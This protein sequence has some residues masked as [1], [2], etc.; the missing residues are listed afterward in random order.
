MGMPGTPGRFFVRQKGRAC[1]SR[2]MMKNIQN[3]L[4]LGILALTVGNVGCVGDPT[5]PSE[6]EGTESALTATDRS[7][8][9]LMV[10]IK[11][12]TGTVLASVKLERDHVV[13]FVE[14]VPG[15]SGVVE[16]AKIGQAMVVTDKIKD[17][18]IVN[19]YKHFAGTSAAIPQTL[20][21]AHQRQQSFASARKLER[22]KPAP[23][24][25]MDIN[26][27]ATGEGPHFYNQAELSWFNQNY[28]NG[29]TGCVLGW[30]W[31]QDWSYSHGMYSAV[32][33]WTRGRG[34]VG[35]EATTNGTLMADMW[36]CVSCCE[37]YCPG[38][39]TWGW[40]QIWIGTV[41]PGYVVSASGSIPD[42]I[43]HWIT[44]SLDP[45]ATAALATYFTYSN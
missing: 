15:M 14:F 29:A 25:S 1:V 26:A 42:R 40:K 35:S 20:S 28:C 17:L 6:V 34:M 38:S 27:K 2:I 21:A 10:G 19:Q 31:A 18:D 22:E 39:S 41:V 7:S 12:M 23:K 24:P 5:V 43:V 11:E 36:T 16:V 32:V 44:D 4:A 33:S 37:W 45:S 3:L 30:D 8:A 9:D 13:H